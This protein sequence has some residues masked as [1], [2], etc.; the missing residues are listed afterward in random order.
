MESDES[1][2]V[3]NLCCRTNRATWARSI[4]TQFR[5]R[6]R[7]P[8]P[9]IDFDQ[10]LSKRLS[11]SPCDFLDNVID[12]KPLPLARDRND[13]QRQSRKSALGIM[14]FADLLIALNMPYDSS[15]AASTRP[16]VSC[17][18]YG[19]WA[20]T[21][22]RRW[23]TTWHLSQFQGQRSWNHQDGGYAMRQSPPSRPQAPSA[24]SPIVPLALSR[25]TESNS[26]DR[27]W[28]VLDGLS[29][30]GIRS[31]R[32]GAPVSTHRNSERDCLAM[33]RSSISPAFR[34]LCAGSL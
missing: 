16:H 10:R 1:H 22:R 4:V 27:C 15:E 13:H 7:R 12:T 6:R 33:H 19:R 32:D 8:E 23:P 17:D 25:C 5:H 18:S 31:S 3:N 24:S 20:H 29:A 34:R 14:G 9:R 28:M 2:A 30:S 11:R 26:S 21:P